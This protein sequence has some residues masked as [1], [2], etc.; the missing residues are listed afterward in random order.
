MHWHPQNLRFFAKNFPSEASLRPPK[1]EFQFF[2]F[3]IFENR[4]RKLRIKLAFVINQKPV[5]FVLKAEVFEKIL[6]INSSSVDP[7]RAQIG[8][9]DSNSPYFCGFYKLLQ[10]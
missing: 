1:R 7:G 3:I 6:Y 2:N 8:G 9:V 10:L 4:K 5:F